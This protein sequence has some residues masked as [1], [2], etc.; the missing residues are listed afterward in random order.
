M[1]DVAKY[2]ARW[3]EGT[4]QRVWLHVLLYTGVRRGDAVALGK[5][6]LKNGV[7]IFITEKGRDR[8]RI[9]VPRPVEPE[10]A[11][12]LAKGPCGDLAFVCGE[13]GEPLV[14]ESFGNMFKAACVEAG[15][16]DKSAHGLRKLSANIWAERGA[17]VNEL[18]ALFGWLSPQMAAHYTE[19]AD[20]KRLAMSAVSRLV[21]TPDEHPM[22]PP[23][24][25]VGP[26][27]Q[28]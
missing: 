27:G 25:K 20:R 28:K 15:I 24:Q 6:H 7:L 18:M 4:R 14:K 23:P 22:D 2:E 13:R 16:T 11:A 10:L 3:S 8:R 17:T 26:T 19:K 12:T 5:Q 9:E 21:R 1:E